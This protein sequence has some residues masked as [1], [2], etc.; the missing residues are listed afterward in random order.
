MPRRTQVFQLAP[1]TGGVNSSVDPGVLPAND[2][3]QA[4]NVLFSTH[5][6]RLK[7]EGFSYFDSS[8]PACTKRSSS[9]TTRT[10]VFASSIHSAAP[11]DHKLVVGERIE[12]TLAGDTRYN[13]SRGTIASITTTTI[14]NDTITYTF[15][16]ATSVTESIIADTTATVARDYSIIANR[17]VWYY[18]ASNVAKEQ[19]HVAVTSDGLLFKY[20]DAGRRTQIT[21]DASATAFAVT[22]LTS[23]QIDTFNNIVILTFAGVGN[24]PKKFDPLD[25][26][27]LWYDLANAPDASIMRQHLGRIWMNDKT[28]PDRLNFSETFEPEIWLGNGDSGALYVAATDGD[29]LGIST[30]MPPYKG[31][32][33]VSK[34]D[35]V[36]Q[37]VGE[38]P[39]EFQILPM[40]GGFGSISHQAAVAV[41]MDDVYF[42]SRRGFHSVVATNAK[43][44]FDAAFLSKKIQPTFNSWHKPAHATMQGVYLSEINSV[45]WCVSEQDAMAGTSLWLF[46]PTIQD[47]QDGTQGVWYRWPSL[48]PQSI[49]VRLDNDQKRLVIG[50]DAGRLLMS[51]NGTYSDVGSTGIPF[52]IKSGTIYPDGNPQTVKAFKKLTLLFKPRSRFNFTAYFKVDGN[53]AQ[54]VTFSQHVTGDLL[55]STFIL[56]SS[57]LG[58]DAILAPVTKDVYGHGR[59]FSVE[60]FQTSADAQV[61]IYG[62]M[63]EYEG[64]DLADEVN[65]ET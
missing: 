43:G 47:P 45:A 32:L 36:Y 58:T 54:A 29:T 33:I 60:I 25:V 57:S 13:C 5:G 42:L 20:D 23:A 35:S 27:C 41:D 30:I 59:G 63:V 22:P 53:P 38:A 55:G 64:A 17:D 10:L 28:D 34:G 24:T 1:W 61:E 4:D 21:K 44:D 39:E 2:L 50:N 51:S 49:C 37:I 8:L 19:I 65:S 46:N 18:N 52:R 11:V 31:V 14:T 7:R 12:V 9:G 6:T 3:V 16:G 15:S 26:S 40:T 56:G 48:N 62:L